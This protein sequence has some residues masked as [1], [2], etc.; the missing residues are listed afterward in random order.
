MAQTRKQTRLPL[1]VPSFPDTTV[2]ASGNIE[3][4]TYGQVT[5]IDTP[6][7][8]AMDITPTSQNGKIEMPSSGWN[9][10]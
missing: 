10:V 2:V 4:G 5:E 6:P 9:E 3:M 1:R 7:F 8:P